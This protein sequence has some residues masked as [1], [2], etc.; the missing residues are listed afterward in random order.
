MT[1]KIKWF[2]DDKGYGWV[3]GDDGIDYFVHYSAFPH[4]HT[5]G[6]PAEAWEKGRRIAFDPVMEQR[7]PRAEGV[8]IIW[9]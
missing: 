5:R 7:G 6:L 4:G 9:E 2:N 8:Q 1:G 3:T